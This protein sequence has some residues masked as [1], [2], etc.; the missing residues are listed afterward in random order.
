MRIVES[1]SRGP[2]TGPSI[3]ELASY[4]GRHLSKASKNRRS[5]VTRLR[6]NSNSAIGWMTSGLSFLICEMEMIY[7]LSGLLC[8]DFMKK[9]CTALRMG[10]GAQNHTV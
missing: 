9:A 8:A 5:G 7:H 1:I 6:S 2:L 10:A 3:I 4:K